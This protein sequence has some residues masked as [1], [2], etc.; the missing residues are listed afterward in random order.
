MIHC[1]PHVLAPDEVA[2]LRRALEHSEFVDGGST[3]GRLIQ[4]AKHNLQ[5]KRTETA[6][7]IETLVSA[8]LARSALFNRA[9]LPRTM[10]PPMFNRYESGM[11]YGRHVDEPVMGGRLRSDLSVT[12]FLSPL[13]S[14]DG[15]EL[16]IEGDL[17]VEQVKLPAGDA[18]IYPATTVHWVE[19]VT[20]GARLAAVVWVQSLIRD[21]VMRRIVC[22]ITTVTESLAQTDAQSQ[23]AE[24]LSRAYADLMRLVVDI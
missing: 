13:D 6:K 20:R 10:T 21:H 1:I 22:D 15:G 3:A 19:P 5:L 8:A 4:S 16:C 7:N 24:L 11:R 9:A 12:V 23:N 2:T 18:V 17:G 14:Y